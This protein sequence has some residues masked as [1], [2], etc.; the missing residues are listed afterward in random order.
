MKEK[1]LDIY[2]VEMGLC[3]T[4]SAA[5]NLI[6]AGEVKVNGEL[7]KK[8]SLAVSVEDQIQILKEKVYVGRG[9]DK[10]L[11]ILTKVDIDFNQ[12]IVGDIGASTG[13]FTQIALDRGA[14]KVYAIDV[15]TN[16]LAKE[17]RENQRVENKEGVNVKF[18]FEL[19]DK[20]E[21]I[22]VDLSFI[23]LTKVLKNILVHLHPKGKAVVLI[24][25]QFE[26]SK[27][28]KNKQGV[29]KDVETQKEVC[30]SI[31]DFVLSLDFKVMG[32]HKCE[33]K[34]KKGNQEFF[35][36]VTHEEKNSV[37]WDQVEGN[38]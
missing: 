13:G 17:L 28:E 5:Q 3:K 34:G 21:I 24:K 37:S 1:R 30:R 22:L 6:K 26:S 32:I 19:E 10:L 33:V 29:V 7:V 16:Q 15:G 36:T 12:K 8:S 4:R 25:P 23:S 31:F 2:L 11:S 38:L 20:L 9:A 14:S 18:P 27:K 35:I